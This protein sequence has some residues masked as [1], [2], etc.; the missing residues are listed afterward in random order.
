[1]YA[2][3]EVK[4]HHWFRNLGSR[5]NDAVANWLLDK[6]PGLYLSTFRCLSRF[7]VDEI[8][9]YAGPYP[10]VDGLILRSTSRIGTVLVRHERRSVGESG[11][12]L[13]KLLNV[14][15]NMSTSFSIL[16]LRVVVAIGL[17]MALAGT[18][19]GVEVIVEKLFWPAIAVGWASL[20]T[21]LVVFSGIQLIVI[22]TIGE[23]VGRLL[24]T[25]NRAP[26]SVI[27]RVVRGPDLAGAGR[28]RPLA[29]ERSSRG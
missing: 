3:F 14:W 29:S 11:Y 9:R 19:L 2:Q 6:P 7:L 21:A 13:R 5:F 27:R 24:M 23:Y 8:L 1:M 10:Y 18:A 17:G 22:G 16:P 15:L 4:Q 28:P 26:Q 20:M 25:V 12:T